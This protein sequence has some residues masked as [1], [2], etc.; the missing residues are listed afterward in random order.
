MKNLENFIHLCK[1]Y[2]ND[3]STP[4][5]EISE[6]KCSKSNNL[7]HFQRKW[8]SYLTFKI[9]CT[10]YALNW[11]RL[12]LGYL[13]EIL[14]TGHQQND[15]NIELHYRIKLTQQNISILEKLNSL[16]RI[17]WTSL[18]SLGSNSTDY[19]N[20]LSEQTKMRLTM[21]QEI[22][23]YS[24]ISQLSQR[25]NEIDRMYRKLQN[26]KHWAHSRYNR[27][28]IAHNRNK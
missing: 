11:L 13:P 7:R 26:E 12:N 15:C 25:T 16:C 5:F 27:I 23:F 10:K 19:A 6:F 1:S 17:N 4:S 8:F 20:F 14:K 24:S 22:A 28:M 9:Q 2:V 18:I 21:R 3:E